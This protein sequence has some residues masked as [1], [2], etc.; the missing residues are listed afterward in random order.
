LKKLIAAEMCGQQVSVFLPRVPFLL[1]SS[2]NS[3][4]D[5]SEARAM[6]YV[7]AEGHYYH[8][9]HIPHILFSS[10]KVIEKRSN[11]R[12]SIISDIFW[13]VFDVIGLLSI[14]LIFHSL[15]ISLRHLRPDIVLPF[16]S[17]SA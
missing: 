6:P 11:F 16:L 10:G 5:I 1:F 15:I 3:T 2:G 9:V 8:L 14:V 13:T 7:N 12:L 17:S 4:A